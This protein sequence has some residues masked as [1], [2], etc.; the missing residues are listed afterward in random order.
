MPRTRRTTPASCRLAM[1]D[2]RD[3]NRI[4]QERAHIRDPEEID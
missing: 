1:L 4:W 3:L 2:R